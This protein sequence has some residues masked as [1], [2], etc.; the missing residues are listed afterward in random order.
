MSLICAKTSGRHVELAK[1]LKVL[2]P[3]N[4]SVR[5]QPEMGASTFPRRCVPPIIRF[6]HLLLVRQILY[7]V[8]GIGREAP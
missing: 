7:Y 3:F 6:R 5:M 2:A 1:A 4:K 8:A